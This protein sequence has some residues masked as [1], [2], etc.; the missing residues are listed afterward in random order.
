M[1]IVLHICCGVC[2]AGVVEALATEGHQV[3]GFFYNP[4]IHPAEEYERRLAS[5]NNTEELLSLQIETIKDEA[6]KQKET[7][8]IELDNVKAVNESKTEKMKC[9]DKLYND[10]KEISLKL[11]DVNK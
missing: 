9:L 4:N 5:I 8:E 1:K 11:G 2:A 3:I 6:E 7:I 10:I